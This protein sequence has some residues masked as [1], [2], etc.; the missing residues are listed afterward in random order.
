MQ[1]HQ[2]PLT[3]SCRTHARKVAQAEPSAACGC[4]ICHNATDAR[5]HVGNLT[6]TDLLLE[7]LVYLQA[8]VADAGHALAQVVEVLVLLPAHA[9]KHVRCEPVN[10]EGLSS[11][12]IAQCKVYCMA[13]RAPEQRA[14]HGS[15]AR[16]WSGSNAAASRYAARTSCRCGAALEWYASGNDPW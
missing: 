5:M 4:G 9:E 8:D 12:V 2:F 11:G 16:Q 13:G 7:L 6:V 1:T 10:A 3:G 14:W 15:T